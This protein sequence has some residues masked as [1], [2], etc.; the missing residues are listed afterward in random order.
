MAEKEKGKNAAAGSTT[1]TKKEREP[2]DVSREG[3]KSG[4][5][6]TGGEFRG[7][8][9]RDTF[10]PQKHYT[11]VLM[12]QGRV[13]LDADWNE[14][15]D[16]VLHT[17]RELARDIF[18]PS[19][20]PDGDAFKIGVNAKK[21]DL[22]I[23]RGHYYVDGILCGNDHREI[24]YSR[25]PDYP[26]SG[27][28]KAEME[29][30]I[31]GDTPFIVWLD[32]W[33]R[34][35][36]MLQDKKIRETALNGPDTATRSQLIWQVRL[37]EDEPRQKVPDETRGTR[38]PGKIMCDYI[39]KNWNRINP[40]R[41][42]FPQL[43]VRAKISPDTSAE[44]TVSP[45]FRYSGVENRLYR[46]E[47][48]TTGTASSP[49]RK[50]G[51]TFKWS[52]Q[53]SSVDYPL[54]SVTGTTATLAAWGRNDPSL[55]T[56]GDRVEIL[57]DYH[58]LRQEAGDLVRIESVDRA[59]LTVTFLPALSYA[60][61]KDK[62]LLRRWDY[63]EDLPHGGGKLKSGAIPIEEGTNEAGWIELEDGVQIQFQ[64]GDHS[65]HTGDYWLIP[66]RTITG[67][68]GWPWDET[69]EQP[70]PPLGI[71]HHT[72]PLAVVYRKDGLLTTCSCRCLF[73][74]P[75]G[76]SLRGEG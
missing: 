38:N 70:R 35:I 75:C 69:G 63:R 31:A 23:G 47:V 5:C 51:A 76:S 37:L 24:S 13:Q 49:A 3:E 9:S 30:L 18:G 17:L 26:L 66:A 16:I 20:G 4:V 62:A 45:G 1:G 15:A 10:D 33:E 8:F 43:K 19:G 22:T 74:P 12:Q 41:R 71:A 32:V 7:D 59:G 50:D 58:A 52:R 60:L 65:Y 67:D 2:V 40:R 14:Q 42:T 48:H 46:V 39:R 54:I 29:R 55:L 25:Q 57:D 44:G 64:P 73:H 56:E 68:V 72:A 28:Q 11:R 36:T 27:E 34:H 53:N 6:G 21:T 61:H